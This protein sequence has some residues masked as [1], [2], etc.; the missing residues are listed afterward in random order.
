MAPLPPA[1]STIRV[2]LTYYIGTD[3][4]VLNSLHFTYTGSAPAASDCVAFAGDVHTAFSSDLLQHLSDNSEL[5]QV[6][7]ID[8]ASTS[9]HFGV[10]TTPL[11]GSRTGNSLPAGVAVLINHQIARRYRGGKPRTYLPFFSSTDIVSPSGWVSGSVS[12]L[13]T[14][15]NSFI[16]A[17]EGATSGSTTLSAFSNVSYFSG[18]A[19]RGTPLV[20]PIVASVVNGI[21]ASQ[22]RRNRP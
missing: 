22:R 16:S 21:P 11:T 3:Q 7:V 12:G 1:A 9:G 18:K 6:E 2:N 14:H 15:W 8:L 4:N 17:I 10:N 19:Q 13:Q 5:T 20:E